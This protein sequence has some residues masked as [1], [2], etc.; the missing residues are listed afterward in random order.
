MTAELALEAEF[1]VNAENKGSRGHLHASDAEN[2]HHRKLR[3]PVHLQI[4][5]QKD[6]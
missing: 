1:R 2:A 5:D 3:T 4:L 6:W